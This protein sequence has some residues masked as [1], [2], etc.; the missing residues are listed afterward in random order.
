MDVTGTGRTAQNEGGVDEQA[1]EGIGQAGVAAELDGSGVAAEDRNRAPS[2]RDGQG[3]AQ[4]EADV[5]QKG[6]G[7]G[8]VVTPIASRTPLFTAQH[9]ERYARQQLIKQYE[10]HTGANLIVVIDQIFPD[11]MTYVEEL[12]F[13]V[14]PD[15]ALHV[16]LASPGGDGETA[17]RMARS[18]QSRCTE[19][20]VI[21]PDLA[22]SAA[23]L[24]CLG[25]D[26]V[27]MGPGGDLGPV[28]P[29]FA[30]SSGSLV[31]A[32]EI[33]S[34]VNE[35]EARVNASPDTYP[36]FASLLSDVNMVMVQQARNALARSEDLVREAL[37]CGTGR[38]MAEVEKLTEQLK[39]PLIEQPAAHTA[40]ISAA[41]AAELGLPVEAADVNSRSW[42]LIW[43][44]WVRYYTLECFPAG[45]TAAYE[46]SRASA[47]QRG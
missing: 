44:L 31:S 43:N 33:V 26:H 47:I 22:K 3:D 25:A 30:R 11:N 35:A 20:T 28:D 45:A 5:V 9:S 12:L 4:G 36:L 7:P 2:Q 27:V 21:V 1:A 39:R 17:I 15:K 34:A 46:G 41:Y 32:K 23:T 38:T 40:V 37:S 13:D 18:M 29:Q 8:G 19:L 42:Q 6:R 14:T 24:L 16:M 10:D